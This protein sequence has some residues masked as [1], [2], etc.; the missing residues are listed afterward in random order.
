[1]AFISSLIVSLDAFF[2]GLSLGLKNTFRFSYLALMNTFLFLLCFIG[3]FISDQIYHLIPFDPSLIVGISFISIGTFNIFQYLISTH[4]T[5][6]DT[7]SKTS[8]KSFILVAIVM[9]FEAML[10]TIGITVVFI[11]S[12]TIIIPL[13]VALAHFV[14]SSSSFFLARRNYIKKIP[15]IVTN[16]ISGLSLIIYGL[17][18]LF[19]D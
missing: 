17:L 4:L 13:T 5:K 9:S 1:M 14:Y 16:V 2:I 15:E 18:A 12:A 8:W 3:F 10:I 11:E 6:K 19:F 7:T